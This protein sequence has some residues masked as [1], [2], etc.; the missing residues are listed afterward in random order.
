M[1]LCMYRCILRLKLEPFI[2][3]RASFREGANHFSRAMAPKSYAFACACIA[4]PLLLHILEG[5]SRGCPTSFGVP[6]TAP[7]KTPNSLD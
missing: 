2:G 4:L 1:S 3:G 7:R 5:N 6:C